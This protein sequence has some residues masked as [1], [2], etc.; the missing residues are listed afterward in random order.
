MGL[1]SPIE[2]TNSTWNPITGCTK[3][4]PGCLH[5]YA[6]RMAVRLKAMGQRNYANGFRLTPHPHALELPIEW[7]KPQMIFVNSMSDLFHD[8]V[9]L[10]FIQQVFKTMAEC[11]QHVFQ[12]LIKRSRRL[13]EIG[14]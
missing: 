3:I 14:D 12:V 13:R 1:K 7:K 8:D 11:P 10:P 6:E 5:C 9:P 2:W 4:S